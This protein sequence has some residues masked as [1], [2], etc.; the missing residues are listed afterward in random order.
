MRGYAHIRSRMA[1]H[2]GP[3]LVG[4]LGAPERLN[5]TCIGTLMMLRAMGM[6]PSRQHRVPGPRRRVRSVALAD[7]VL[8]F[9]LGLA[10][11]TQ[12]TM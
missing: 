12:A 10:A 6:Y 11:C 9:I 3:A 8:M 1:L 7:G 5:Y 2:S 4:N